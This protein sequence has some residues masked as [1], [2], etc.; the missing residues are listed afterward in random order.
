MFREIN[1]IR[2]KRIVEILLK[3]NPKKE[4]LTTYH[5]IDEN[6]AKSIM[7]GKHED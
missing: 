7:I 2:I 5:H 6:S 3:I 4:N 1:K